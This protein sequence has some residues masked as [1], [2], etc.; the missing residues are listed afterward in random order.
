MDE[1]LELN[2]HEDESGAGI[3]LRDL[4]RALLAKIWILALVAILCAGLAFGYTKLFTEPWYQSQAA[5][6]VISN[7]MNSSSDVT[8]ANFLARDCIALIQDHN[9]LNH[10]LARLRANNVNIPSE[11]TYKELAK[12]ISLTLSSEDS[13]MI[14]ITVTDEDPKVAK[15]IADAICDVAKNEINE[16]I[17]GERGEGRINPVGGENPATLP[18]NQAGPSLAKNVAVAGLIG[19][20]VS[21]AAVILVYVLDDKI[22]N[23]DQVQHVLGL[24]TLGM[25]PHQKRNTVAE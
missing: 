24:S 9:M 18:S 11:M 7:N 21:A 4:F 17:G 6:Y 22:K 13:R 14:V 8:V 23:A 20:L 15:A 2:E 25:I 19:L 12:K 16:V 5:L 10:A 3:D 1:M